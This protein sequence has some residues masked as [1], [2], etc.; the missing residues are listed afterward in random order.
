MSHEH[1]PVY[2][3]SVCRGIALKRQIKGWMQ[4]YD[5]RPTYHLIV[6]QI[7]LQ[8][9]RTCLS[10]LIILFVKRRILTQSN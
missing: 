4:Y 5:S 3:Q 9:I 10:D 6:K 1:W 7:K 2:S 8:I